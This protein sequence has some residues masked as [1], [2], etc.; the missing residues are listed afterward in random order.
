VGALFS[1]LVGIP[2]AIRELFGRHGESF[3]ATWLEPAVGSAL[4]VSHRTEWTVMGSSTLVALAGIGLAYVFYGGGYRSPALAFGRAFPRLLGLVRDKFRVDELYGFLLIRPLRA[5]CRGV[6]LVVDRILIDRML[7]GGLALLVDLGGRLLR[8]VQVGDVQRYLAVFAIGLTA[9]VWL[10]AR[11]ASPEEVHIS[12]S[13]NTVRVNLVDA[14]A[15]GGNLTYAFDFD[16]DGTPDRVSQ[17]P[18]ATWTFSG[19]DRYTIHISIRDA[20]WQTQR[21]LERDIEV[22]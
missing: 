5:L 8:A 2:P 22:R 15:A 20:R 17:T 10:A 7:V 1:G 13:G 16:G 12:V 19:P 14:E 21:T 6:F 11:P 4:E 9:V 18:S 3:L